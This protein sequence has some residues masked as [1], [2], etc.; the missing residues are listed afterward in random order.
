VSTVTEW[1][2]KYL[3]VYSRQLVSAV[4]ISRGFIEACDYMNWDDD[5]V[6]QGFHLLTTELQVEVVRRLEELEPGKY[7]WRPWTC[8]DG[9]T[10]EALEKLRLKTAGVHRVVK[11]LG[12][13]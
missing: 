1:I 13:N 4:E 3:E 12:K 2:E 7:F 5:E 11:V 10:D 9:F 6:A 8:G